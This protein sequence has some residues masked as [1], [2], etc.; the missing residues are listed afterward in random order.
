VLEKK[1]KVKDRLLL[2][3]KIKEGRLIKIVRYALLK[4]LKGMRAQNIDFLEVRKKV[5]AL[6][7]QILQIP[8]FS[9]D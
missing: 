1:K 9:Y 2:Q 8:E 6:K 4:S 3:K 5:E 7:H